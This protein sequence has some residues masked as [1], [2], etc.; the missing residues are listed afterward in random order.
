MIFHT[1]VKGAGF[2]QPTPSERPRLELNIARVAL[3]VVLLGLLL[4]GAYLAEH[5]GWKEGSWAMTY[6]AAVLFGLV[7]GAIF[8]EDQAIRYGA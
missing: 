2:A 5:Y 4:G 1:P 6:M 3:G 8:G 7:T